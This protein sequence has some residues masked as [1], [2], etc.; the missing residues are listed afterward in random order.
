[1]G[2]T[3]YNISAWTKK[4]TNKPVITVGSVGID[5]IFEEEMFEGKTVFTKPE[6]LTLVEERL[7]KGDFDLVAVG[8]ALLADSN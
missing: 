6:S 4:I 7:K 3:S 8:R 1:M 5:K 2:S